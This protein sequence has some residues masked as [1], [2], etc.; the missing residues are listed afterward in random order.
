MLKNN[1]MKERYS[2]GVSR[3]IKLIVSKKC[4]EN[5]HLFSKNICCNTFLKH[6]TIGISELLDLALQ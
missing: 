4:H 6:I 5:E 3:D 1:F 2:F